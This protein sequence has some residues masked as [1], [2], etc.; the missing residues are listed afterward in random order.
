MNST[1][2]A[3]M[4]LGT[5]ENG[6]DDEDGDEWQDRES[7]ERDS[8]LDTATSVGSGDTRQRIA[9]R[10]RQRPLTVGTHGKVVP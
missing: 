2:R 1:G 7:N 10:W 8:T 9:S 6:G 4:D 3:D 5:V